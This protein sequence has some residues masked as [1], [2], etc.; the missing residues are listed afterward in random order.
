MKNK[1]VSVRC[2]SC[3][4][5]VQMKAK[6]IRSDVFFCPVCEAG[7]IESPDI[8]L[9][10]DCYKLKSPAKQPVLVTI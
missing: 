1:Y 7:E 9:I 10:I 6:S 2:P 4:S 8:S 5:T 3:G